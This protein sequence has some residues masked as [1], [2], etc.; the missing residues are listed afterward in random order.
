MWG[1]WRWRENTQSN[2]HTRTHI[3]RTKTDWKPEHASYSFSW[4]FKYKRKRTAIFLIT[5]ESQLHWTKEILMTRAHTSFSSTFSHWQILA[6]SV[7]RCN[8]LTQF[9]SD[10]SNDGLQNWNQIF[11]FY[12]LI[13]VL[14]QQIEFFVKCVCLILNQMESIEREHKWTP[15]SNS[16]Y[17]GSDILF[18]GRAGYAEKIFFWWFGII[19]SPWISRLSTNFA[20]MLDDP[21][22]T[23]KATNWQRNVFCN[24][25]DCF[26]LP[27]QYEWMRDS[28][29]VI[30]VTRTQSRQ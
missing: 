23:V 16:K 8:E 10:G 11:N 18:Q 17:I 14:R 9:F 19:F 7:L 3:Q 27:L 12:L 4:S 6:V 25:T 22:M 13:A 21:M 29:S 26:F 30:V 20:S 2:A 15:V 1:R 24:S 5:P 28:T